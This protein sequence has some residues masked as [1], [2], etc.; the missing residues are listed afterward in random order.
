MKIPVIIGAVIILTGLASAQYTSSYSGGSDG[1]LSIP[2]VE[3]IYDN[4]YLM[5]AFYPEYQSGEY[6][7]SRDIWL[8]GQKSGQLVAAW[9][10]LGDSI[11]TALTRLSGIDWSEP[12]IKVHLMKYLPVAGLYEPLALPVE[13]I[14]NARSIIAAPSGSLQ[15]FTMIQFMAGRNLLQTEFPTH[16]ANWVSTHPLFEK[17]V[18][19]FDLLALTLAV[20]CAER[21]IPKDTLDSLLN[22]EQWRRFNPGWEIYRTYFRDKWILSEDTTL[23]SYLAAEKHDSPLVQLTAPPKLPDEAPERRRRSRLVATSG[24]GRLGMSVSRIAGGF[25]IVAIDS[26]KLAYLGGLRKGDRI[27]RVDGEL[28]R[29]ARDFFDKILNRLDSDGVYLL[30]QRQNESRGFILQSR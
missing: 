15:I 8:V 14:R 30:V 28:S 3:F 13:G 2:Q 16:F 20:S 5:K 22:L 25:E 12:V 4:Y 19:R 17:G 6:E 11:L 18:Y 1:A 29:N 21:I 26:T 7:T 23:L 9:D 27:L 24:G 10:S